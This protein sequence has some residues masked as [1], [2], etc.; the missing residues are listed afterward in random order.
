MAII[1]DGTTGVTT[2]SVNSSSNLISTVVS[3]PTSLSLKT[4]GTTTAMTIDT[5]GNFGMNTSP[6]TN[7]K[8]TVDNG[9][10]TT[11]EASPLVLKG[12]SSSE[13]GGQL[14]LWNTYAGVSNPKK[15]IRVD[16][17][18]KLGI[19]NNAYAAQI[20]SLDDSGNLAT[21]GT[22]SNSSGA[23]IKNVV[24][25]IRSTSPT[26]VNFS[27]S[28]ANVN[29]T[30]YKWDIPSAGDYMLWMTVRAR[31][32]GL[33]TFAKVRLYNNN[34]STALT[35]SETM[36]IESQ[37]GPNSLNVG[38]TMQWFYTF[39]GACTVYLQ[40]ACSTSGEVG[41]QSD[42]NGWNEFGYLKVA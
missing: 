33:N 37:S 39:S 7:Y 6:T 34:T 20:L 12:G 3:S 9:S 24:Y 40:G 8:I 13:N 28:F 10:P 21:S 35:N 30:Y 11:G 5:S 1:L 18:G 19:I 41:I 17:S 36:M 14:A 42:V 27:S 25:S 26:N 31:V 32:W 2:P 22:I 15:W 23:L 29:T 16:N 38:V 4:N